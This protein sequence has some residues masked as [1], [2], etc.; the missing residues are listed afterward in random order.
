MLG[1]QCIAFY[2]ED[3]SLLGTVYDRLLASLPPG[4]RTSSNRVEIAKRLISAAANGER[5]PVELELTAAM[6]PIAT[7]AA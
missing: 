2:P 3:L 7:K 4:M 5:D 6:D 1:E